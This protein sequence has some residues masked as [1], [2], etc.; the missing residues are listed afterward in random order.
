MR[1]AVK[2]NDVPDSGTHK[3]KRK[4]N[5]G[6]KVRLAELLT[7]SNLRKEID[8]YGYEFSVGKY[9]LLICAVCCVVFALGTMFSLKFR[10]TFCLTAF[11]LILLPGII[12]DAYRNMYE[13]K[14]FLDMADYME[15]ILYSFKS[16]HKILTALKDTAS[17]PFRGKMR[18][19]VLRAAEY[20]ERGNAKEDGNIYR[21]AFSIIEN[22]YPE[23]RISAIHSYLLSA[24]KNGGDN[25]EAVELLLKDKNIWADNV[26]ALQ[27]ERKSKRNLVFAALLLTVIFAAIFQGIYRAMPEE[28]RIADSVV[29]QTAATIFLMLDIWIFRKANHEI[30]KSWVDRAEPDREEM[31]VRYYQEVMLYDEKTERKLSRALGVPAAVFA[32]V[33]YVIDLKLAGVLVAALA[34][35]FLNQHKIGYRTAY[36][37][38]VKE[39]NSAFPQWLMQMALLLQTNNVHRAIAESVEDAPAVLRPALEEFSQRLQTE[40]DTPELFGSFLQKFDLSSV[41]SAM[42]MMYSMSSLGSGEVRTQIRALIERNSSLLDKAEKI[43]NEEKLT[44]IVTLFYMPQLTISAYLMAGMSMFILTFL[45]NSIS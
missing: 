42:Q 20:I 7:P 38:V 2:Q 18:E 1:K 9:S 13:H 37:R 25:T 44:G 15:Q 43:K 22:E 35:F 32:A 29:M 45:Q 36:N 14:R 8:S 16:S 4:K 31:I 11:F 19:T 10:Y 12:L 23:R 24:E 28:Y 40:K 17:L 21:E 3:N 34:I 30:A 39:I 27:E 5:A 26:L 33:L 41:Q 6:K